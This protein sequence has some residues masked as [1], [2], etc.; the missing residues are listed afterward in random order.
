MFDSS[1]TLG[2]TSSTISFPDWTEVQSSFSRKIQEP[3][4]KR[5]SAFEKGRLMSKCLNSVAYDLNFTKPELIKGK[6]TKS[7]TRKYTA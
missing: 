4:L 1:F 2:L 5:F 7:L 6:A 3:Y